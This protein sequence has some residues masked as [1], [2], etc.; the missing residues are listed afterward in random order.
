MGLGRPLTGVLDRTK[1]IVEDIATADA[2]SQP[3]TSYLD[4]QVLDPGRT[5]LELI[6]FQTSAHEVRGASGKTKIAVRVY[7]I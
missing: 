7:K 2:A 6:G 4:I 5:L 3:A 1:E